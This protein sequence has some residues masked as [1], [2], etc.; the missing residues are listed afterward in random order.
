M[1]SDILQLAQKVRKELIDDILPFWFEKMTDA[2][3][4]GYYGQITGNNDLITSAP[5]GGILNARI[6]WTFS[7][8]YRA[9][10]KEEY[11]DAA[12][13]ARDYI[14]K[15]FTDKEFGG[16]YWSVDY[17][18]NP[19]DT[20]KQIYS[21]A[22]SIYALSEFYLATND[23]ESLK[24]AIDLFHLIEKYSYDPEYGG[25]FE[26]YSRDWKLLEDLRL[27]DK[28]ANEKKTMNTHLH[29]LE[30][31]TNLYRV[32]KDD[33]L[34]KQLRELIGM[35]F[36]HIVNHETW[37]LNL[38]FD[39]FWTLKSSDISYG[40][41]IEC[42]WLL[43]EAAEVLG[44]PEMIKK[45]ENI[46]INILKASLE[47]MQPDNSLIYEKKLNGHTDTQRHWWPQAE[48]VVGLINGFELTGNQNWLKMAD[49]C[50]DFILEKLVDK[51]NGEWHWGVYSDGSINNTDDKAG[52]WK[53][54]YHN[55]RMSLEVMRRAE[56][57]SKNC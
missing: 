32:W 54:P 16:I 45:A 19:L 15:F 14:F 39:E 33:H 34:S 8:A 28:D 25:Y 22:F 42:S 30:A 26:A 12:S 49:G 47:G 10:G 6:L 27:S 20:K 35:F 9:L 31:Y 17:K 2:D 23:Q 13:R 38:F 7:A 5:K 40:H 24:M 43:Y 11:L 46:C 37:H 51:Q 57:I 56:I 55:G 52:F 3:N 21:L 48:A 53:C 36:D 29:I 50:F 1:E 4:G 18:G 41:D 44:D